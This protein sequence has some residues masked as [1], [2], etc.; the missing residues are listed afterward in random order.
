[1]SRPLVIQDYLL[2]G[3]VMGVI[4]ACMI[5]LVRSYRADARALK[6]RSQAGL[7]SAG[8]DFRQMHRAH[9]QTRA[10]ESSLDLHEATG[11]DG[12]HGAGAGAQ[13]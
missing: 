1:M 10:R 13:D 7:L 8:Q 6:R 3:G 2:V 12:H 4:T 9:G 11:I 5:L